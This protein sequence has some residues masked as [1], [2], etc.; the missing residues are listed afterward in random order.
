MEDRFNLPERHYCS[1]S[2]EEHL[3]SLKDAFLGLC[4]ENLRMSLKKCN[5]FGKEVKYIGQG[6][7][8][9]GVTANSDKIRVVQEWFQL[10]D[11]QELQSF[12]DLCTYYRRTLWRF[13]RKLGE[14]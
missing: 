4:D 1:R 5:L 13:G 10:K 6:V 12:L 11:K 14:K 3:K 7:S 2:F 8:E 9:D